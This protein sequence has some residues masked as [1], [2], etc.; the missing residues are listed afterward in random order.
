MSSKC[1]K[2]TIITV[3]IYGSAILYLIPWPASSATVGD[4]VVKFRNYIEKQLQ[5]YDIYLVFDREYSTK[6]VTRVSRGAQV[7]RVHQ[8]TTVMPLPPPKVILTISDSKRK[9]I[10]LIVDDL[11]SNTVF[12]ETSNIRGLVVTGKD[13]VPV[14]LSSTVTIKRED[15]RANHEEADN[16]LAHQ[17]VVVLSEEIKGVS[18]ISNSTDVI[19]LLL[20]HYVKQKITGVV[21]MESL[22][23]D[24]V[25]IDI[26][27]TAIEHRN[28][29][30]DH[31]CN[32]GTSSG[33][34]LETS[35]RVGSAWIES[36]W[37]WMGKEWSHKVSWSC[38]AA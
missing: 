29:I 32:E 38:Y 23:K 37:L 21:I 16:I 3:V 20:H 8:L 22:V 33:M 26:K 25:A 27:A 24:R 4:F 1:I 19:V 34:C 9:L 5:S 2:Q 30:P 31:M 10:G 13:L 12:W 17:M 14:E 36:C 7:S 11:S 35:H 15:L 28:I 18:V 6:G